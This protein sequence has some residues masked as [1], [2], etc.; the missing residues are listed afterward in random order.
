MPE[1]MLLLQGTVGST[2]YGLARDGSDVDRIGIFAYHTMDVLSLDYTG[3]ME[4]V[5]RHEPDVTVHEVAKYLRLALKC[6][7]TIM[8][9]MWLP[10][11]L[12]ETRTE[13]GEW[14]IGLRSAVLCED[15]VRASYGGY[16]KQQVERLKRRHAEGKVGFA[17]DL[18]KRTAKHARHCFR[19]LNQGRELLETGH[20]PIQVQNPEDYFAFDGASV[21]EI[22]AR[23]AHEDEVFRNVTSVLPARPDKPA[24]QSVLNKIRRTYWWD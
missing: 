4:S 14:I 15:A 6:N 8:E 12:Y 2:A 18:Q 24:V 17:S 23:F 16:A 13:M 10:D 21:D 7:P 20:L 11:H 19:L 3:D 22:V 1:K 9:L 5:V